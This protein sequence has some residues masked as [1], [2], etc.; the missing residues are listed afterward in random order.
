MKVEVKKAGRP[1]F[2]LLGAVCCLILLGIIIMASVSFAPSIREYGSSFSILWHHI[3]FGLLP[4]I[5]LGYVLFK[6][7]LEKIKKLAPIVFLINLFSLVLVFF[8]VIGISAGGASRWINFG[9]TTIQ[10]SEF[11]K[12]TFILYLAAWLSSLIK[13]NNEVKKNKVFQRANNSP[14]TFI[15]F[16]IIIGVITVLMVLQR[17]VS[18]WGVIIVSGIVMYFLSGVSLKH[19]VAIFLGL[20]GLLFLLIKLVPYRFQR[21]LVFLNPDLDPMGKGYQI[22]QALITVGSGGLF[23]KGFGLSL[24]RY[25][26]FLPQPISDSIFALFSEEAGFIGSFILVSLF[27][28]FAWRG[29]V[30]AKNSKDQFSKFICFGISLW[31]IIQA[32][33]NI[34]AMINL[35]PLT[36]IPLPFISYGGSALIAEL[37]AVGIMLNIS[38]KTS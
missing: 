5:V 35:I 23:G 21:F 29:F 22:K 2:I 24:Q 13:K 19:M 4:G 26:G 25:G 14:N 38:T 10:P 7:P 30:I 37:M 31:I 33:V 3:L 17:D 15:S 16:L 32:F 9:F 28:L 12:V 20:F 8:P 1:D 27:I 18:T 11:L 6:F 36:G 34:G